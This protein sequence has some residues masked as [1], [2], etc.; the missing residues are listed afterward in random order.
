MHLDPSNVSTKFE[1]QAPDEANGIRP[2]AIVDPKENLGEEEK[3]KQ[4]SEE[5]VSS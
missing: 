4:G 3:P 1:N 2:C 5:D